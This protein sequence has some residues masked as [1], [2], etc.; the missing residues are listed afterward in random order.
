[1]QGIANHNSSVS[2][3]REAENE[4]AFVPG[5]SSVIQTQ[6]ARDFLQVL[7]NHLDTYKS[8][9]FIT[10]AGSVWTEVANQSGIP[11]NNSL[12]QSRKL[13][14]DVYVQN[15][16]SSA[17]I[18]LSS[19]TVLDNNLGEREVILRI[20]AP[21]IDVDAG[22]KVVG[23]IE[24]SMS[25]VAILDVINNLNTQSD[26]RWVLVNKAGRYLADTASPRVQSGKLSLNTYSLVAKTE[27]ELA[28]LVS[29]KPTE[30]DG[31]LPLARSRPSAMSDLGPQALRSGR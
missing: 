27:P 10:P 14:D 19:I 18:T 13:K 20:L 22:G 7:D 24:L 4:A 29:C 15:S 30:N 17:T 5:Q 26:Q 25:A 16:L 23:D 3:G 8:I 12:L 9:R 11:S 2:F 21:V 31:F 6:L 1:M 28:A